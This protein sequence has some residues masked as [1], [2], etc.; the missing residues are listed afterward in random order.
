MVGSRTILVEPE[1]AEMNVV[2]FHG[3]TGSPDTFAELA[4][5]ISG[6]FNARVFVPLLPGHG[7][8]IDDL[9]QISF[10]HFMEAARDHVRSLKEP[11]LPLFVIGYC[12][13]GYLGTVIANEFHAKALVLALTSFRAR[14]PFTLPGFAV[15][16]SKRKTWS[17]YLR[18]QEKQIREPFFYYERMPGKAQLLCDVGRKNMKK[19]LPFLTVPILTLHTK[20]D[21]TCIQMSGRKIL[22]L[23]AQNSGN[24]AKVLPNRRHAL[25]FGPKKDED[26]AFVINFLK[27][28]CKRKLPPKCIGAAV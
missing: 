19:I 12:F 7:T 5:R 4:Q 23:S 17:K 15:L 11:G 8:S 16:M 14:F 3:Y 25:F 1:K 24:E 2:I 20:N 28:I 27:K 26:I 10:E 6:E 9:E 22:S 13:G 21:P 18:R